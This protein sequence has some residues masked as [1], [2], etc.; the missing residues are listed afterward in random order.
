MAPSWKIQD[1]AE[2][3]MSAWILHDWGWQ[4]PKD[5]LV[6]LGPKSTY[7]YSEPQIHRLLDYLIQKREL[8]KKGISFKNVLYGPA[9]KF[10]E[11]IERE[12]SIKVLTR[13]I[14]ESFKNWP[15]AT[16][17]PYL[18]RV[19]IIG[20][21][22][23]MEFHL[24]MSQRN[25]AVASPRLQGVADRMHVEMS[26]YFASILAKAYS[27]D[28]KLTDACFMFIR[29]NVSAKMNSVEYISALA[30]EMMRQESEAL[31]HSTSI[32]STLPRPQV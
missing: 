12:L 29:R 8:V 19:Y 14:E 4:R 31:R 10:Q 30:K 23:S 5:L 16:N 20:G 28:R 15:L 7:H 2:R 27:K 21:L 18:K 13:Q 25:K 11:Q 17:D 26:D 9:K 22:L 6:R 1:F 32:V 24:A 3:V